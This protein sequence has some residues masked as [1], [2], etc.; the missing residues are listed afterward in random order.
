MVGDNDDIDDFDNHIASSVRDGGANINDIITTM[1]ENR[2]A[3]MK[4]PSNTS[5]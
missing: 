1:T 3:I 2:N 5:D 4:Q